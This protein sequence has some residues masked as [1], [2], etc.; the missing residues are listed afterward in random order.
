M[1]KNFMPAYTD[2]LINGVSMASSVT[3]TPV[4]ISTFDNVG[5]QLVWAGADPL[6]TINF[7]VSLDYNKT[8]GNPGTWT[9]IDDENGNPVVVTPGGTAGN[10]YVDFNQLSAPYFRVIYTTAGS[11]SG[12]L[13]AKIGAKSV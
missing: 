7:Q 4:G 10:A 1:A 11:S 6:G 9:T 3:G 2:P 8:T 5:V 12:T 13:T